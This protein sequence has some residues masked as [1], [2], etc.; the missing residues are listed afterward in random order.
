MKISGFTMARNAVSLD[1]P[2]VESIRSLL[3][4]CDEIVVA[5]GRSEDDT[6]ARVRA[7]ADP[8]IRAIETVWDPAH[9]V[10]GAVNAVQTNIALEACSGDWC[11]YLQADEVLHEDDLP[12]LRRMMEEC[13]DDPRVEGLLFDYLH[14]WGSYDT[15]QTAH[16]WYRHEVRAVRNGIGIRSWKSAQGFRRDGLKLRVRRSGARVFHY[17][18]VR[19]PRL[20][21]RKQMA[22]DSVHHD[23]DWV[24]RRHPE[25]EIVFDYG[26]LRKLARFRETHPAVMRER[27]DRKAWNA[28]LEGEGRMRHKHERLSVRLLSCIENRILHTRIGEYR[29]YILIE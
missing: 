21:K 23:A 20:M 12:K 11:V 1:Y 10:H 26:D 4:L 18:W 2:I 28:P 14:F 27:I 7:I 19:H 16:H 17:G 9:F 6:L 5:V 24:R 8:R 29:N 3:P 13:A 15:Y 22:L 25:P